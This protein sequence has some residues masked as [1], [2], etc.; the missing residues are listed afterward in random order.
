MATDGSATDRAA[1]GSVQIVAEFFESV[2]WSTD[3]HETYDSMA[4]ALVQVLGC[5]TAS[6]RLLTPAGNGMIGCASS[7]T[8]SS[9]ISDKLRS[10][11]LSMG[12]LPELIRTHEPIFV[13]FAHPNEQDVTFD[14]A[15]E[16]G[17]R[18]AVTVPLLADGSLLGIADFIYRDGQYTDDTLETLK[19]FGR[20]LGV[21]VS[22]VS[23]SERLVHLR[24]LD[25]VSSLA[26]QINE[27]TLQP[28]SVVM[29][30][31]DKALESL[32]SGDSDSLKSGLERLY[33]ASLE[34]YKLTSQ[35]LATLQ[36]SDAEVTDI[37]CEVRDFLERF[38][39]MWGIA[40]SL[41]SPELGVLATGRIRDQVMHILNE[42]LANVVRHAG[43]SQVFVEIKEQLGVLQMSI[44][45]NG[46]GFDTKGERLMNHGILAMKARASK[47]GGRLLLVSTPG[48]GTSVS[49]DL[50]LHY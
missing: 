35:E 33:A 14:G 20:I 26:T 47:V 50:P 4:D 2:Q 46:C 39:E 13:D 10:L 8:A 15:V 30:E 7:G 37:V 24:I 41:T 49:F 9:I 32:D 40:C 21:V 11:P 43:A 18:Y 45:D 25:E 6:I 23:L 17:Y 22:A 28:T 27:N 5:D 3:P 16:L 38:T 34:L 1:G 48:E 42:A 29:L 19:G 12:R 31:A 36:R 44:E